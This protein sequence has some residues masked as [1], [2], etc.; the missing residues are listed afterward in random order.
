MATKQQTI[1]VR[2]EAK[3]KKEIAAIAKSQRRSISNL[4]EYLLIL[5]KAKLY[6]MDLA[7]VQAERK[8]AK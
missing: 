7:D 4:G 5:G 6:E 1:T 3:L 2:I 8:G